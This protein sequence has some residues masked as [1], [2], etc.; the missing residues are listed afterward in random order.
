MQVELDELEILHI[1]NAIDDGIQNI[2]YRK[3]YNNTND[4]DEKIR[5]EQIET[6]RAIKKKI[7]NSLKETWSK[8]T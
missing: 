3:S 8:K 1:L 5:I 7:K 4:L 2:E 6:Y